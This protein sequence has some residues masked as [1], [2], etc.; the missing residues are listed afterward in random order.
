[1]RGMCFSVLNN[2]MIL[3]LRMSLF[4]NLTQRETAF[5]DG[6]SVGVL[7][8]R[9]QSDC[10]AIAKCFS[11]NFNISLRNLFQAIGG[12]IYLWFLSK[13]IRLQS[14]CQAIAKCFSIS[15][16]IS[17]RNLFQAIGGFIYLW[18][19]SKEIRFYSI[20]VRQ[21]GACASF[22][23]FGHIARFY[24]IGVRQAGAY[25][26]FVVFGHIACYACKVV[27]L[28][29]GCAMVLRGELNSEQLT[30]YI[31][32]TEFVVYSSLNV[33]DEFT[34]VMEAMGASERVLKLL[35]GKPAPQIGSTHKKVLDWSG[36]LCIKDVTFRYPGRPSH[37]ALDKVTLDLPPGSL[38]ALVGQ[39]GSGKSSVVMLLKRLYD[40]NEGALLLDGVDLRDVD[41]LWYRSQIG[42]VSQGVL[43]LD[44]VDL[45]K[46]DPLCTGSTTSITGSKDAASDIDAKQFAE[47]SK[48]WPTFEGLL[49]APNFPLNPLDSLIGPSQADIEDAA[50]QANAHDFIMALP[51]G[52]Q[53]MVTDKL[54]SGGQ[55]QR[56][57]L[58][59]ALIRN[60][61]LLVLD[62]RS[63][64]V[65]AHR[66]TT[67]RKADKIVVMDNGAVSEVGD[68]EALMEKRG[69][70]WNLVMRQD[71]GLTPEDAALLATP[72]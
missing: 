15:S 45:R 5:F 10:Q 12:F 64:V 14:D 11:I 61:R 52:Y 23:V 43:L 26:S 29:L 65:I 71:Y 38:T 67:V 49:D 44:D 33:C 57:S 66:L 59:R 2:R 55:K 4:Q 21:A 53:T 19:L 28:L 27:A 20:G 7:T 68:H 8:S 69:I 25:A 50:R 36:Q 37:T 18:F 34:E 32:Y 62:D 13:E 17:L 46:V 40:P 16:N 60:P 56:I 24:S 42:V 58:A 47:A 1:M 3:R 22:V 31:F 54:L 41:P 6:V 70:Y 48:S 39:S 51:Q 9:L 30:N 63:V 72:A 35:D